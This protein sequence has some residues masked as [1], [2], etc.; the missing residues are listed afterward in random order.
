[1]REAW[2]GLLFSDPDLEEISERRDPVL[3]AP[4]SPAAKRKLPVRHKLD[5]TE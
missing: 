3:P 1:M 5:L 4:R 2:R